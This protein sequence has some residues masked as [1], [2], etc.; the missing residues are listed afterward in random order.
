[1]AKKKMVRRAT[2]PKS[3]TKRAKGTTNKTRKAAPARTKRASARKAPT[4]SQVSKAKKRVPAPVR[5]KR[6]A[7]KPVEPKAQVPLVVETLVEPIAPA[8]SLPP[9]LQASA[10]PSKAAGKRHRQQPFSAPGIQHS[11]SVIAKVHMSRVLMNRN[12]G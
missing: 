3:A 6:R 1:M 11:N 7:S 10:D 9:E 8:L 12:R 2:T 4:A 5:S